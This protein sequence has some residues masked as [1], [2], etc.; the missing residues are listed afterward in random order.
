[1]SSPAATSALYFSSVP[2]SPSAGTPMARARSS[3][4][5]AVVTL[6]AATISSITGSTQSSQVIPG[7]TTFLKARVDFGCE[8][9]FAAS[10]NTTQ[11]GPSCA[12]TMGCVTLYGDI[13][14]KNRRPSR[15]TQ[16]S[17]PGKYGS[18]S[19]EKFGRRLHSQR[20]CPVI[21]ALTA[22]TSAKASPVEYLATGSSPFGHSQ[23]PAA[24]T[25][26]GG[27]WRSARDCPRFLRWRRTTASGGELAR[28]RLA[29]R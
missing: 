22:E 29:P 16:T 6:P 11:T 19:C 12:S 28:R 3:I 27:T 21:W 7:M 15:L 20:S 26:S 24:A 18:D 13:S 17:Q 2:V 14:S 10:S 25:A 23:S 8:A 1:M 4:D 5:P 9:R